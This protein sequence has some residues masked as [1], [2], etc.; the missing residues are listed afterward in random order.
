[1]TDKP[2]DIK[3]ICLDAAQQIA[4]ELGTAEAFADKTD[5]LKALTALYTAL[6]KHPS[7]D[8]EDDTETFDFSKGVQASA[9]QDKPNGAGQPGLQSRRRPSR[10]S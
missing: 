6:R 7:D 8:D 3:Q 5:A 9:S 1:M 4:D 2:I 10:V